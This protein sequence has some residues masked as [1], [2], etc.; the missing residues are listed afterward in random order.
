MIGESYTQIGIL[1]LV[2]VTVIKEC[3]TFVRYRR[4]GRNGKYVSEKFCGERTRRIEESIKA[5]DALTQ[6]KLNNIS[7]ALST[8]PCQLNNKDCDK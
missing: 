5:S 3:F 8:R 7:N 6:E 2:V 1:G 4:N